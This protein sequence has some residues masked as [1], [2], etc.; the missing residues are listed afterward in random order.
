MKYLERE[1]SF[2]SSLQVKSTRTSYYYYYS[3]SMTT[4]AKVRLESYLKYYTH[5]K[6]YWFI[7]RNVS[8]ASSKILEAT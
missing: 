7:Q 8:K 3:L 5:R 1:R 4:I 6:F 2:L